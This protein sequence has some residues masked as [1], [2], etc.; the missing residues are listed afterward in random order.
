MCI[1]ATCGGS[2]KSAAAA[3]QRA[4]AVDQAELLVALSHNKRAHILIVTSPVLRQRSGNPSYCRVGCRWVCATCIAHGFVLGELRHT[5]G[6]TLAGANGRWRGPP[7]SHGRWRTEGAHTA[8]PP[9]RRERRSY[10]SAAAPPFGVPTR[11]VAVVQ[12][13]VGACLSPL[14]Q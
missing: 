5:A 1:V 13:V 14:A 6:A 4:T 2:R 8:P 9:P 7:P 10:V 12:C 3:L 11:H